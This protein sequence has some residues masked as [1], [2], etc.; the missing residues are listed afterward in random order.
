MI[1]VNKGAVQLSGSFVTLKA[2]LTVLMK[3]LIEDIDAFSKE[4]L[5]DCV[6]S[7]VKPMDE[8]KKETFDNFVKLLKDNPE[9]AAEYFAHLVEGKHDNE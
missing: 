4:E 1:H 5:E 6:D 7:A 9:G 2:E 3:V 8:I